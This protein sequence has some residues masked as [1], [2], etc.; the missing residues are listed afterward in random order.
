MHPHTAERPKLVIL[1]PEPKEPPAPH[2]AYLPVALFG[3]VMGL[4]GLSVAW[5]VAASRYGLP[6]GI[7]AVYAG[8]ALLAFAA[9]SLAYIAKLLFAPDAVRTEFGN[10]I[11]GT[12]FGTL[13]ISMLL[14]PIL[15]APRALLAAQILW[16]TGVVGMVAFA[17]HMLSRW[18]RQRQQIGHA[19]PA[20]IVPVVGILDIPLAQPSLELPQLHGLMMAS[21][22]VGLFFAVP[23]FTIVLARLVFEEKLPP[24][25]QPTVMI[26]LAPFAVGF[27]SYVATTGQVDLFAQ[28]LYWLTLFLLPLLLGRLRSLVQSCPFRVSWWAV[29]FPLAASATCAIR[30]A[31]SEPGWLADAIALGLLALAS[32]AITGLLLRTIYGIARGELQKLSGS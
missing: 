32:I 19:I 29:S 5:R 28:S 6:E 4:T 24:V 9:M 13:L 15:L 21:L 7:S 20:W 10:P 25:L 31:S 8:I 26:L 23:L 14:V 18:M 17:W 30:F 12:L 11:T 2:L 16:M 27:S 3:S 1:A 22:A